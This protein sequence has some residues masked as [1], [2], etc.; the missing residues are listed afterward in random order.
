MIEGTNIAFLLILIFWFGTDNEY[1][2]G[3]GGGGLRVEGWGCKRWY[4]QTRINWKFN[5]FMS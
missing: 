1:L 3:G 2:G 4:R 5:T